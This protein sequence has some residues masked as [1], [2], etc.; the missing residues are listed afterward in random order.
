VNINT[1]A[2]AAPGMTTAEIKVT[3]VADALLS[4]CGAAYGRPPCARQPS[5]E[6][7]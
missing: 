5:F 3:E 4:Q 6:A 2:A 1:Q 7:D